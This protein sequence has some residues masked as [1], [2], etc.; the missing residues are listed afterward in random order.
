MKLD[1]TSSADA[2]KKLKE[3]HIDRVALGERGLPYEALDQL[4]VE[5]L[6]G[7]R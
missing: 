6:L 1:P 5:L 4:T 2:A 3:T 7:V